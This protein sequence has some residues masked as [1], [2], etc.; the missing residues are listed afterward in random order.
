MN[1]RKE[2]RNSVYSLLLNRTIANENVFMSRHDAIAEKDLPSLMFYAESENLEV[3]NE[4]PR[5]YRRALEL[6]IIGYIS[7]SERETLEDELD[8]FT[9]QIENAMNYDRFF[10]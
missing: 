10:W 4:S 8:A 9:Q 1:N 5:V 6:V 3:Q 2:I 7:G